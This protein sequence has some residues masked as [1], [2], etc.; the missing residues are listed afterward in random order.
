[1]PMP[2]PWVDKIFLKLEMIYGHRFLSQ[3]PGASVEAVKADWQHEL[4]GMERNPEAIAYALSHLPHDNPVNVLQFREICRRMPEP[5]FKALAQPEAD[6]EGVKK[7][8]GEVQSIVKKPANDVLHRQREHMQM[9]LDGQMLGRAQRE[10]WRVAL[11][12]ELLVKTGIDTG[13][14]FKL[15]ALR[16]ALKARAA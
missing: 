11:R 3:W 14:P 10:F 5:A 12:R 7:V 1:M 8:L 2:L 15:D 13:R 16:D 9:E 6:K 4:D